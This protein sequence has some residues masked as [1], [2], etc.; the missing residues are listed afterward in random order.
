MSTR[1]NLAILLVSTAVYLGQLA[2][3]LPSPLATRVKTLEIGNFKQLNSI[4]VLVLAIYSCTLAFIFSAGLLINAWDFTTEGRCRAAIDLCLVFYVGSKVCL[5]LFLVE[6]AHQLVAT[7]LPR[8]RDAIYL[9][10]IAIVVFGF[11]VLAV[12]AFIHPVTSLSHIDGKCRIGLPLVITIPLLSY[13]IIINFALTFV[14]V[15]RGARLVKIRNFQHALHCIA[16]ALP[17]RKVPGLRD[18]VIA[19]EFFMGR[20]GL[21]ASAIILPTIANLVILF[22]LNGHENGWLCFTICTIDSMFLVACPV[23]RACSPYDSTN[24]STVT[25][26]ASIIHWLTST[27]DDL[28]AGPTRAPAAVGQGEG[29]YHEMR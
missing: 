29:E 22:A 14:F 9:L 15:M 1:V 21:G 16:M 12:F 4:R 2:N 3:A 7:K 10:G 18:P 26:S 5:Y 17:F 24:G 23:L 25:W 11:G 13:D 19:C 20:S 27:K 8:L 6:R 28:G